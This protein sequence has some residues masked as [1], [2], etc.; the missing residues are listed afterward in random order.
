MFRNLRKK[1]LKK[2][3]KN[4]KSFNYKKG[5]VSLNFSLR[6][7]IKGDLKDFQEC[8]E[9]ALEEVKGEIDKLSE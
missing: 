8:L 9:V 1:I 5:N 2:D 7:D 3:H 6:I 4:I